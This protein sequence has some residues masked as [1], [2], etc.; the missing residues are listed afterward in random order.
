MVVSISKSDTKEEVR[1]NLR[2][3]ADL[4]RRLVDRALGNARSMNSEAVA[5]LQQALAATE[6]M[7]VE[8]LQEEIQR[9]QAD[10][11]TTARTLNHLSDRRN[12]LRNALS[13]A[14]GT[15]FL[16]TDEARAKLQK[17]LDAMD[18]QDRRADR[19]R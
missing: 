9:V 18:A 3:P 4:H 8:A 10:I 12:R 14:K 1:F 13:D 7:G 15:S 5:L 17:T 11:D 16:V 2:L 19:K 6:D